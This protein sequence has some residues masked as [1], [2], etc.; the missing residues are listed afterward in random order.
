[1][2]VKGCFINIPVFDINADVILS[3]RLVSPL[4]LMTFKNSD[5]DQ[6][7]LYLYKSS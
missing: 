6:I 2:T 7:Q 5:I 1:M 3:W 4:T